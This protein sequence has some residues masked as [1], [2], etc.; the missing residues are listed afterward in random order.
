MQTITRAFLLAFLLFTIPAH[1]GAQGTNDNRNAD[2]QL[3]TR[4]GEGEDALARAQREQAKQLN[5]ERQ[6]DLK[7]DA[8][9][10]LELATQLKDYVDKT[11]ENVMSV[12]VINKATEIEKL[13]KKVREKMKAN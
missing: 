4:R 6:K 13:A 3:G 1:A 7:R 5:L 8:D 12:T 11:N 2:P 10:L 9:K